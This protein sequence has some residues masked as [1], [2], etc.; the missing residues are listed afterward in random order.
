MIRDYYD[1]RLLAALGVLKLCNARPWGIVAG[2]G[3]YE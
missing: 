3:T 1:S 2:P